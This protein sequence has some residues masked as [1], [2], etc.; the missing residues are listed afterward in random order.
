MA[1]GNVRNGGGQITDECGGRAMSSTFGTDSVC[2]VEAFPVAV[3][4]NPVAAGGHLKVANLG[5]RRVVRL[6]FVRGR[7]AFERFLVLSSAVG[8]HHHHYRGNILSQ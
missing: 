4:E 6:T 7:P 3:V 5:V 2:I 1:Y 8:I